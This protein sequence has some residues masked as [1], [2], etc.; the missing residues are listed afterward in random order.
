[1]L[2]VNIL[3]VKS[4][5]GIGSGIRLLEANKSSGRGLTFLH[6]EDSNALDLTKLTEETLKLN[7]S[8]VLGEALDEEVALL[9]GV[10]ESLL[11][12]E[13]LSL[14]LRGGESSLHVELAAGLNLLLM[15]IIDCIEGALGSILRLAG[16]VEADES[17]GFLVSFLVK[18]L[19]DCE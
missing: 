14:T 12:A 17:E 4:L 5:A 8:V 13:Y 3:V 15:K 19:H 6:R 18:S 1:V 7:I 9:L 11:L 16:A 10:L 2:A